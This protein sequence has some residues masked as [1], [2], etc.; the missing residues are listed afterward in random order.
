MLR[1]LVKL[2]AASTLVSTY[3][4]CIWESHKLLPEAIPV[5]QPVAEKEKRCCATSI[6]H[7]IKQRRHKKPVTCN[8]KFQNKIMRLIVYVLGK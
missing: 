5:L 8:S 7:L 2:A 3:G 1:P 4:L 6:K